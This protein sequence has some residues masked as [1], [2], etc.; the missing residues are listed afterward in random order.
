MDANKI[1]KDFIKYFG[2][3]LWEEEEIL[4]V[5]QQAILLVS[6]E[7]LGIEPIPVIFEDINGDISRYDVKEHVIILNRKY[8]NDYKELM[9]SCLHELEHHYQLLYISNFNTPKALRWKSELET[10]DRT[11]ISEVEMDAYAF[12]RVVGSCEFG[13]NYTTGNEE[14]ERLI[15]KYIDSGKLI[16]DD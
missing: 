13:I 8:K 1:K 9:N 11:Q 5:F 2:E 15:D 16:N 12:S 4:S 14:L 6:S 7:Y 10:Y 3:E